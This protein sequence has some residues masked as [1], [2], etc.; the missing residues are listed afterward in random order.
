[1]TDSSVTGVLRE[2]ASLQSDAV[3]FTFVDYDQEWEGVPH[4]LTWAQLNRRVRSLA[5]ELRLR[6]SIGDRAVILAPQGLDY[7]VAFL[8]SLQAGVIGVPLPVPMFGVHDERVTAVLRDASPSMILTTSSVADQVAEYAV[9]QGD[10]PAPVVIAVD[11]LD[12]DTPRRSTSGREAL[13]PT[14]YLQYTSGST[15]TPAGVMVSN[16]NLTANFEQVMADFF[17]DTGG[18][19][20]PHTTAVSWL[21]FYHDMGLMLGVCAPILA[22]WHTVFTT[23][24]SFLARP[25]RWTQLL[26]SYPHTVTAAPNFAFELAAGRTS[27]DDMRGLDLGDV[28]RVLSGSERVHVAT[29]RRF[30][31]RFAKFNFREEA[32]RPSYGLAEATLYVA[33][34]PLIQPP[35]VVHFEPEKLSAG[36]AERCGNETGTP[37]VSYGAPKSP[38]VR[39][40]EPETRSER[41]AEMIGEIWVQGDNVCLGYWGKPEQTDETFG[42]S[43]V[44]ASPG[45]PDGPWLRTGDLGFIS[46]AELFIAG[47]IKDILIVRGLNHYP[48]D[49][50]ATIQEVSGGRVAAIS[51]EDDSG[52]Q[53]VAIIE[54]KTRGESGEEAREKF[55]NLKRDVTSAI[56]K[57]HGL[58]AADLVLVP[59]G[60]IPITTSGKIRRAACVE[61]YR[62]KQ[63][64]RLD[65]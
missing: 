55:D 17:P 18:V 20:P 6:G 39:I 62:N 23:P 52:E 29:L 63:F 26:A 3:A 14:A 58:S 31:Q 41:P 30:A 27:D 1:M 48:D 42:A 15:R 24:G 4:T 2:R 37:L 22:G 33:T 43:I 57:T 10:Q 45:T 60:S 49:I 8:A 50:E 32:L 9:P 38:V 19:S 5:H 35:N 28:L 16:R 36:H 56:S 7:V 34:R 54:A 25:A 53:L 61:L 51:V 44:A 47:R 40:V 11:E 12:L 65:T 13:P 46:E 21:P 59:R 64:T